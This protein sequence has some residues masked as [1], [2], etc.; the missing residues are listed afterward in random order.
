LILSAYDLIHTA[1]NYAGQHNPIPLVPGR[2]DT[3]LLL[4]CQSHSGTLAVVFWGCAA[5]LRI[6][7]VP[8]DARVKSRRWVRFSLLVFLGTFGNLLFLTQFL[9]PV[10][11]FG[12]WLLVGRPIPRSRTLAL[13]GCTILSGVAGRLAIFE[14]TNVGEVET[15]VK[16][17]DRPG[18]FRSF[19][20]GFAYDLWKHF[21]PIMVL[22]MGTWAVVAWVTLRRTFQKPGPDFVRFSIY[23]LLFL[24]TTI[25]I[26]SI[27]FAGMNPMFDGN[28]FRQYQFTKKYC[29]PGVFA[30]LLVLPFL[31]VRWLG[32][33]FFRRS[34]PIAVSL[35]AI[36][37]W[38]AVV[39][40]PMPHSRR[41]FEDD[42]LDFVRFLDESEDIRPGAIGVSEVWSSRLISLTSHKKLRGIPVMPDLG[43]FYWLGNRV[44][45]D[46]DPGTP[47][48]YREAR[49]I[50]LNAV[51]TI[52]GFR[53]ERAI[54]DR[55][56]LERLGM[57]D[58]TMTVA[59]RQIGI[60][61]R[62]GPVPAIVN[63]GERIE[64]INEPGTDISSRVTLVSTTVPERGQWP[65]L[66]YRVRVKNESG[67]T[68]L[69]P[70]DSKTGTNVIS[71][72]WSV[73]DASDRETSGGRT[74][75]TRAIA[76]G[77]EHD[78]HIAISQPRAGETRTLTVA[79]V[80]DGV[81]WAYEIDRSFALKI[82]PEPRPDR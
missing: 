23:Q 24:S 80:Q 39:W 51:A 43:P 61:F 81:R 7:A 82:A 69:V 63:S 4:A 49:F 59:D 32:D 52:N 67:A 25:T 40:I 27:I 2:F 66:L 68:W 12:M 10:V 53:T 16:S 54:S 60:G 50:V 30:P 17:I 33:L 22:A 46:S 31:S 79:V 70:P 55:H 34:M 37:A 65:L 3:T 56:I 19:T 64:G 48:L 62:R 41:T 29:E 11:V 36:V 15:F 28:R 58:R 1:E 21:D 6:L 20:R 9:L 73:T 57:A 72:G 38:Q 71:V 42:R 74:A 47:E 77:A 13:I 75:L 45:F 76:P 5:L 44:W 14:A 18:V 35:V 8:S 26:A 78:F